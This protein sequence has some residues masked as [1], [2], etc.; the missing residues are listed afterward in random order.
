MITSRLLPVGLACSGALVA[1][2]LAQAAE[3]P[4][5]RYALAWVRATGAEAC[6]SSPELGRLVEATVGTD[7][8]PP[9]QATI[10]VD[11]LVAPKPGGGFRTLIRVNSAAGE[12]LG[13]RRLES[14]DARCSD[15]TRSTLLVLAVMMNPD[16]APRGLPSGVLD[17]LEQWD[18]EETRS[19]RERALEREQNPQPELPRAR[20]TP[21]APARAP[22][23]PAGAKADERTPAASRSGSKRDRGVELG[24]SLALNLELTPRPTFGGVA[25]LALPL[26]DAWV[27]QVEAAFFPGGSAYIPSAYATDDVTIA[28][29]ELAPEL[30]PRPLELGR[31]RGS[32]CA[33]V[34]G[35]VRVLGGSGLAE[36]AKP[37]QPYVGPAGSVDLAWFFAEHGF[38]EARV[39]AAWLPRDDRFVFTDHDG[40]VRELFD[41]APFAGYAALG[42][43]GVF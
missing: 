42:A 31:V 11:A 3:P 26:G 34:V 2:S 7:L 37:V 10:L 27:A 13:E 17:V 22:A 24:L 35:G 6:P 5:D 19:A 12:A 20:G 39:H 18:D 21:A 8:V 38:V 41:P 40:T 16:A 15:V 30:C 14:D 9:T 23:K 25:T 33:G 32:A 36:P 1:S 29:A 4:V 43:G 28:V